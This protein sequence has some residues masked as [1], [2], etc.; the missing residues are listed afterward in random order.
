M[1]SKIYIGETS[2]RLKTRIAEHKRDCRIGNNNTGLSQHSW[3]F[4]HDFD[5][6]FKNIRILANESITYKRKIIE[7]IFIKKYN[8]LCVNLQTERMYINNVH[9]CLLN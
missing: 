5:F 2:R 9:Q 6:D 7:S 4:Y 8:N 1:C 3:S